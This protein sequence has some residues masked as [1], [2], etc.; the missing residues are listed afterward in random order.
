MLELPEPAE[1]LLD[2]KGETKESENIP[3]PESEAS[4][5]PG[6]RFAP[7]MLPAEVPV[8]SNSDRPPNTMEV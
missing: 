3:S 4:S 7:L 2:E 5:E 8:A 1:A 6:F